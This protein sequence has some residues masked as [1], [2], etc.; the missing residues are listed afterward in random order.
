[1]ASTSE[2]Y[3]HD[4]IDAEAIDSPDEESAGPKTAEECRV[5]LSVIEVDGE[6]LAEVF[7]HGEPSEDASDPEPPK[8]LLAHV[9]SSEILMFPRVS[10]AYRS[11]FLEQKYDQ[12]VR[13]RVP[14]DWNVPRD[15]DEFNELLGDLPVGF[16]RR[17]SRG[18]GLKWENRLIIEA[19]ERATTATELQLVDGDEASLSGETF[20]LGRR[21]FDRVRKGMAQIGRRSQVRALQDRRFLAHNEIVH[22]IDGELYPKQLRQARPG[23]FFA[24]AQLSTR[25]QQR[26]KSDRAAATDIVKRDA[27]QIARENPRA[28]LEL[29]S[30]IERVTL[31]ELIDR[32]DALLQRNPDERVWQT[33]FET[34]PF[35]LSI[36]FPH[37]VLLIR[38]QAH[39][40]GTTIDG[41]GETIA[42]FLFRNGLAGSV[43]IVEIKTARTH[44]LQ[45]KTFR[46]TMH[47]AHSDL[48]AAISQALDQRAELTK[49]FHARGQHPSMEGTHV[50][51]V[52]CLVVAGKTPDTRDKRGSLD[53]FRS[54]TKDVAVITF[55]E[56][57]AKLRAI[58]RAMSAGSTG[59]TGSVAQNAG[60]S[61]TSGGPDTDR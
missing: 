49:N 55:D 37:P 24:L 6:E 34:H 11:T 48:C 18:L 13:I 35:V 22:P 16:S 4:P 28:L 51:H 61:P 41:T 27:P 15:I 50:W 21:L 26:S 25:D 12:I 39:V 2:D 38:G 29:R 8:V 30:E 53:L 43:A 45:K 23:E 1:M 17:A 56:L 7:A 59:A 19:I 44:L 3:A 20:S 52:H 5:S 54:A 31:G 33:F 32:F 42:D 47:A 40:G 10:A 36:A 57:L 46:G 14:G 9:C 60:P 58:H